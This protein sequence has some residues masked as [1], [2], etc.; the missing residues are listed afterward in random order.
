MGEGLVASHVAAARGRC[1]LE[2]P[3]AALLSFDQYTFNTLRCRLEPPGAARAGRGGSR[4]APTGA[5]LKAALGLA[6]VPWRAAGPGSAPPR[7]AG[8]EV[9]ALHGPAD[10]GSAPLYGP[11]GSVA[12]VSVFATPPQHRASHVRSGGL[13][14]S[15]GEG[16]GPVF[17]PTLRLPPGAGLSS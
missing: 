15:E 9:E 4:D 6:A 13:A 5:L 8:P 11:A 7:W 12:L 2:P 17:G 3:G 16:H 10:Q 14:L 1:R